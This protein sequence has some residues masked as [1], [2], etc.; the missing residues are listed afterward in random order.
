MGGRAWRVPL[1][2]SP[3]PRP[4]PR[5]PELAPPVSDNLDQYSASSEIRKAIEIIRGI[6]DIC[7][8]LKEMF[9][10]GEAEQDDD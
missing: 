2:S 4:P 3:I 9:Y 10:N 5:P 8:E 7:E 1:S 6:Y